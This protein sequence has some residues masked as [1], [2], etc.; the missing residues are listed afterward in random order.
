MRSAVTTS[1]LC[2]PPLY[3]HGK[4]LKSWG[5]GVWGLHSTEVAFALLTQKPRVQFTAFP[6]I[7]QKN[8]FRRI[9]SDVLFL[10]ANAEID[11]QHFLECGKA[12][13]CW[14]NHL[15][16]CWK[17]SA[18]KNSSF[19]FF[20]A[21]F[22][23]TS[24]R[25]NNVFWKQKNWDPPFSGKPHRLPHYRDSLNWDEKEWCQSERERQ[26]WGEREREREGK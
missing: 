18:E 8:Y 15:K 23:K 4:M 13:K 25:P 26:R 11:Q 10:L 21:I 2:R 7:F 17:V 19:S 5:W 24:S 9:I 6:R 3:S 12:L 22:I 20:S 1:V 16:K 14:S